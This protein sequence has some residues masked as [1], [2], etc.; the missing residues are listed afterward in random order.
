MLLSLPGPPK[1]LTQRIFLPE[2]PPVKPLLK[3]GEFLKWGGK[4]SQIK[5]GG[6][7]GNPQNSPQKKMWGPK[8]LQSG[9]WP[10]LGKK[11]KEGFFFSPCLFK[12]PMCQ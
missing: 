8:F 4:K 3:W 12:T 10:K 7:F 11:K 9:T 2:T 5:E 1:I 6:N